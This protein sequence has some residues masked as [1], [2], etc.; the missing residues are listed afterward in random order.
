MSLLIL[1]ILKQN[2]QCRFSKSSM[3][4]PKHR[5]LWKRSVFGRIRWNYRLFRKIKKRNGGRI[6]WIKIEEYYIETEKIKRIFKTDNSM[7]IS[8]GFT[9]NNREECLY[10]PFNSSTERD[11]IL[12]NIQN[13]VNYNV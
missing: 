7:I 6:M 9:E 8:F 4:K 11:R 3:V 10:I 5:Q 12:Q 2:L 13:I 1:P